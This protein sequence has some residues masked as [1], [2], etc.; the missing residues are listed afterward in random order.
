MPALISNETV[1]PLQRQGSGDNKITAKLVGEDDKVDIVYPYRNRAARVS[2]GTFIGSAMSK[3][4]QTHF[5]TKWGRG[6]A[7]PDTREPVVQPWR[8]RTKRVEAGTMVASPYYD[9][10]Q[11]WEKGSARPKSSMGFDAVN[12]V[13]R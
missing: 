3:D 2:Q 9:M 8:D 1:R 13:E 6:A 12:H 5:I 10:V 11:R 7:R 4:A